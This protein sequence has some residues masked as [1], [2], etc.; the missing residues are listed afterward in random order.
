MTTLESRELQT[1][2][3]IAPIRLAHFVLRSNH[4]EETRAW[5]ETVLGAHAVFE[6][7]FVCFMTYD[8][9]H[10]RVAII[11][12]ADAPSPPPGAAGV[13]HIAFTFATLGNLLS[14]FRR[15]QALGIE[16]YWCINHGPTTSFY[17][18]DP[19]E[20]LVELQF[21]NFERAEALQGWFDRGDFAD[22]PIGVTFDPQRLIERFEAGDAIEE[23]VKQ[24]SA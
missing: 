19:D 23:L 17:Y 22:N 2:D 4:F 24:G 13:D 3:V 12:T 14:T 10:H 11:N 16:P 7:P 1:E 5:Y 21:D 8:E 6:N 9:E 18:R 15:L 20:N